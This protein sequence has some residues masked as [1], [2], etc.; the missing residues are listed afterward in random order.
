MRSLAFAMGAAVFLVIGCMFPFMSMKAGGFENSMTLPQTALELYNNGR[1]TLALLVAGFI[2]LVPAVL[3]GSIL[4]LLVPLIRGR[5]APWLVPAGRLIFTL[6]PWSM[7]EVFVI[8]VIV[9]LVKL[10]AMATIVLGISF[11]SYVAF[12]LS[13]TAALSSLDRSYVWGAVEQVSSR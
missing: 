6:S 12:S 11:W 9:S 4:V 7:V 13:L 2:L 5:N 1:T 10:A 8:G 3:L